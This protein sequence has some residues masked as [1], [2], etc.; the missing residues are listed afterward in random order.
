MLGKET[1][2]NPNCFQNTY[3]HTLNG[4]ILVPSCGRLRL[5]R[6]NEYGYHPSS[7]LRKAQ[8]EGRKVAGPECR[9]RIYIRIRTECSPGRLQ[10]S[11]NRVFDTGYRMCTLGGV[12]GCNS[13]SL[14]R[15]ELGLGGCQFPAVIPDV[16][17]VAHQHLLARGSAVRTSTCPFS[18]RH[19]YSTAYKRRIKES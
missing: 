16:G 12:S 7:W 9:A 17:R 2:V 6:H 15:R 8:T 11:R 5:T 18:Y 19:E 3:I 14:L 4:Y 13:P 10:K 1:A